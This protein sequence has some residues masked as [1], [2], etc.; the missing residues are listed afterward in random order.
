MNSHA[1]LVKWIKSGMILCSL[2]VAWLQGVPNV[3]FNWAAVSAFFSGG[4]MI[5]VIILAVKV[6]AWKGTIEQRLLD[7]KDR[8]D[9]IDRHGC[10]AAI[11]LHYRDNEGP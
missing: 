8:V 3:Q 9:I 2:A 5:T 6:G 10:G 1:E 4:A 7:L 11:R